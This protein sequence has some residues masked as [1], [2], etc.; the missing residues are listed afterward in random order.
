MNRNAITGRDPCDLWAG[1]GDDSRD[2]MPQRSRRRDASETAPVMRIRMTN[3]AR[4]DPHLNLAGSGRRVVD[5]DVRQGSIQRW[6]SHGSHRM[7]VSA[8]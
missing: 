1:V 7:S 5:L 2:L 8:A 3:A 4:L 6:Q